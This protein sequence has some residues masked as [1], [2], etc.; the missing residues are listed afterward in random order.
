MKRLNSVLILIFVFLLMFGINGVVGQSQSNERESLPAGN[1]KVSFEPYRGVGY[2]EMPVEMV[3]FKGRIVKDGVFF[4]IQPHLK[5]RSENGVKSVY[6]TC[7]VYGEQQPTIILV[8]QDHS[9]WMNLY[10]ILPAGEELQTSVW[11]GHNFSNGENGLFASLIKDGKLEGN[12]RIAVGISKVIFED[13]SVWE[14]SKTSQSAERPNR[15]SA[16]APTDN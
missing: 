4:I 10:T 13:G 1:W 3:S 2:E 9:A 5:N 6:L 11:I 15:P 8:Q 14:Q 16:E 7:Y 12:Y